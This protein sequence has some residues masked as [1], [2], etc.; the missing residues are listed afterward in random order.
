MANIKKLI[1]LLVLIALTFAQAG[2]AQNQT[3]TIT[4]MFSYDPHPSTADFSSPVS[5]NGELLKH[6]LVFHETWKTIKDTDYLQT[7]NFTLQA[8]KGTEVVAKSSTKP[9]DVK[10]ISKGQSV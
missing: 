2:M 6:Q 1:G 9:F 7:I 10:K 3:Q 8:L 5:F 4:R